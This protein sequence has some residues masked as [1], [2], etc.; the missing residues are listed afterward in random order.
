ME[1]I[2]M[3]NSNEG[4]V[5]VILTLVYVITTVGILYSTLRSLQQTA[6]FREEDHR[7]YVIFNLIIED[8]IIMSVRSNIGKGP[9]Y[10]VRATIDPPMVVDYGQFGSREPISYKDVLI[11]MLA[12]GQVIEDFVN[13]RQA[14]FKD[15]PDATFTMEVSY[16][17]SFNRTYKEPTTPQCFRHLK[18]VLPGDWLRER[19]ETALKMARSRSGQSQGGPPFGPV[20]I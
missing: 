17:D 16:R 7:P 15:N 20:S 12:P 11:P 10:D 5:L 13:E 6:K 3:L 1:I 19:R 4:A 9:A 8:D 18:D 2:R 14:F